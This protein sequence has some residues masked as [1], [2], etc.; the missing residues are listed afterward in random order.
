MTGKGK[1]Y[2][3]LFTCLMADSDSVERIY[4]TIIV[5][6]FITERK[7][8]EAAIEASKKIVLG[9]RDVWMNAKAKMLSTPGKFHYTCNLRDL[10][11]VVQDI[12]QVVPETLNTPDLVVAA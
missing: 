6:H 2:F 11:R 5:G 12:I 7:I 8:S 4:T 10:S 1:Q 9:T 3:P